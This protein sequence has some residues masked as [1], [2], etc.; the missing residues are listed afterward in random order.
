VCCNE[1][2]NLPPSKHW[3]KRRFAMSTKKKHL[4]LLSG[5]TLLLAVPACNAP[6]GTA[7]TQTPTPPP[8]SA[9]PTSTPD[10]QAPPS[11]IL[12]FP[13]GD[14]MLDPRAN[15]ILS[16]KPVSDLSIPVV[17]YVQIKTVFTNV[18]PI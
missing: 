6:D 10:A 16:W 3:N 7:P 14:D 9:L 18:P 5:I 1:L 12:V 17:Y 4:S 2:E 13:V 8:A 15:V 11:P